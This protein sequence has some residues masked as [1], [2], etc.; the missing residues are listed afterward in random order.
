MIG[1]GAQGNPWVFRRE[2]EPNGAH[3]AHNAASGTHA[4]IDAGTLRQTIRRHY[5][6][7]S[8]YKGERTAM[9]EMR[10]HVAWYL[11]GWPGAAHL[12]AEVY[13][14]ETREEVERVLDG[15]NG[16]GVCRECLS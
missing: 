14:M 1:R 8:T 5:D 2:P 4:R 11:H 3:D 15:L 6:M 9:L 16:H 12:R 13:R 7:L 10:K